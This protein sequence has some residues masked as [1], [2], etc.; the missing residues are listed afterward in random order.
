MNEG[1][2]AAVFEARHAGDSNDPSSTA[3]FCCSRFDVNS[4]IPSCLI[5]GSFGQNVL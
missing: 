5:A 4:D 2:V 1:A 3:E